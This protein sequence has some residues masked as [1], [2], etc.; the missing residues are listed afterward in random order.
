MKRVF[1]LRSSAGKYRNGG[2]WRADLAGA[3]VWHRK[4]DAEAALRADHRRNP[5]L[6]TP[7][8]A[9]VV[10]LLALAPPPEGCVYVALPV[11]HHV[12]ADFLES[13]GFL[14][15]AMKVDPSRADPE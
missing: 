15:Q 9:K 6:D 3:H 11:G 4:Q 8:G 1:V 12:L 14:A 10:E 13:A 2:G 7:D 5:A